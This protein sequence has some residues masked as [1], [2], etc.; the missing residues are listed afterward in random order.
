MR[1]IRVRVLSVPVPV[2]FAVAAVPLSALQ[3]SPDPRLEHRMLRQAAAQEERGELEAAEATL[4]ELLTLQPGSSAA[5]FALERVFRN[6]DRLPDLIPLLGAFLERKPLA[7]RVWGLKVAVLVE[8]EEVSL[9]EETVHAWIEA[10]SASSVPYLEGAEAFHEALGAEKGTEL[11]KAGLEAQG[12]L[13]SLLIRLGDLYAAAGSVEDAAAVWAR[14][15]G[16]DEARRGAVFRRIEGL[17]EGSGEAAAL[18]VATLG[19]EPTTVSRLEVGAE[20]ALRQDLD[21]DVSALT[22]AALERLDDR[23]ARTF[24][25]GLA[26]K[27]EDLGRDKSALWAYTKLRNITRD[28]AEA[29]SSDER[30]TGA[31]LAAG[32][33]V[34]ALEA[35]RRITESHA[36]G[37]AGRLTAWTDEL[38]IQVASRDTEGARAALAAFRAE[39]PESHEL[40]ALSA[41][42]ASRLLG[43]RMRAEAMEVLDGIEGPGAALE[44]AFLLLEGDAFREGI[45]ALQASLPELEPADATEMLELTLALSELT[46][47]G[48]KLAAEVAIAKHRGHPMRG[49]LAV[50]ER[51]E[52]LPGPDRPPVLALGARVAGQ[53]G[54]GDIAATFRRR[55]VAE[56]EEAREFP[57]A[58][59]RLARAVAAEPGG[60]DEA[61]RILEAL[62]VS[63]PD[64]PVVP[65]ARRELRRIR[66]RGSI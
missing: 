31:A 53:A 16:R 24:L 33:T 10:D 11:L 59:L 43:M 52:A 25:A 47:L 54:F 38:R 29:R 17:D 22:Q 4:R 49:V 30:L 2:L 64:S 51:I 18:I 65:G 23:E 40:D 8:I 35:M 15:L 44:R 1:G 50:Q 57:E 37:S 5:V 19:A 61:V 66:G 62:I 27:A 56:H 34:A 3:S 28:P 55:I 12:E 9:L 36:R 6:G 45:A 58:A 20:L 48:G 32:D 39:F 41:R 46:P 14:A 42:L 63:R 13:P 60:R 26:R 7:G 21:D